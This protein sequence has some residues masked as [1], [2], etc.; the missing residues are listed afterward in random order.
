MSEHSGA[1]PL[2]HAAFSG[3]AARQ[4]DAPALIH[5]GTA[6]SYRVLDAASDGYAAELSARGVSPGQIVPIVLPRSPQLVAVQLAVLKCGAAYVNIDADWPDDRQAAIHAQAAPK[7]VVTGSAGVFAGNAETFRVEPEELADVAARA[8]AFTRADVTA[9]DPATVFFTSGT[10]GRPK[11][12]VVPH[13]AVTRLFGPGGLPGFGPGHVT[14]Q[15]AAI[16]WDM[17]AFELWG[18]LSSGGCAVLVPHGHLLPGTLRKLVHSAGADTVWLTTSL[19]NLFVDEDVDCFTGIRQLIVGG[20]KLS[21]AH[22]RAFLDR[23]PLIPLRNGYG[24]A[25]NCMLTTTRLVRHEDCDIV[26]GIPVG[27]PVPGTTVLILSEDGTRRVAGETDEVCIAGTGLAVHYLSQPEMTAEKF[28]V[29]DVDGTPVRVYRTGDRGFVDDLGVLH[30]RGRHDRQV[31]IS[32]HRI[33]LAE[34]EITARAVEGVRECLVTPLKG[35]EGQVTGL[36]LFYVPQSAS[37]AADTG[38]AGEERAVRAALARALPSY[39]VPGVIRGLDRF[40][41]TA[42]GK[43]DQVELLQLATRPRRGRT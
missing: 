10:T 6:I 36:A 28:P 9:D 19:F 16:A 3:H 32:G 41:V 5:D 11:G 42:N 34:I 14:P 20:E 27:V 37:H 13:R 26:E 23:H 38:G 30:F 43:V 24:P 31:K 8:S 33:E 21:A 25:E 35:P 4:P 22:V 29:V 12:V 17:Y 39:L 40:P 15:A 1:G 7:V 18:Q 2:V